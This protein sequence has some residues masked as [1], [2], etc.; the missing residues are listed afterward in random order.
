MRYTGVEFRGKMF[1]ER[2]IMVEMRH[3]KVKNVLDVIIARIGCMM[4]KKDKPCRGRRAELNDI[5]A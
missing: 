5:D 4:L 3:H 2:L 1:G